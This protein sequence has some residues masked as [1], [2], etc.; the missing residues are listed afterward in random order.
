MTLLAVSLMFVGL[1]LAAYRAGSVR[2]YARGYREGIDH[3]RR[4]RGE[5]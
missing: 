2:G 1:S 5:L 3:L 4:F